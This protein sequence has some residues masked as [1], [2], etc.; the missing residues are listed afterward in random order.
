[1]AR[2][3]SPEEQKDCLNHGAHV[4]QLAHTILRTFHER[5]E[6]NIELVNTFLQVESTVLYSLIPVLR[7]LDRGQEAEYYYR[8]LNHITHMLREY[9][10]RMNTIM[11]N[12]STA[13]A[14]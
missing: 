11:R 2:E 5:Q 13:A 6:D 9:N 7:A 3:V 4:F 8:R 1:M 10:D 14:A 12:S